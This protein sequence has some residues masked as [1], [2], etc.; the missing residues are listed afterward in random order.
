MLLHTTGTFVVVF[1]GV[2]VVQ[3]LQSHRLLAFKRFINRQL[4]KK[5]KKAEISTEVQIFSYLILI[6]PTKYYMDGHLY[7]FSI[8]CII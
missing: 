7:W 3:C 2:S 4:A 5:K 8:L 1:S 6:L